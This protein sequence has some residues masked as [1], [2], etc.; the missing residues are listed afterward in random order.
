MNIKFKIRNIINQKW[1]IKINKIINIKFKIK[2]FK[3]YK[4]NYMK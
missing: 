4:T 1:I 3:K 2:I